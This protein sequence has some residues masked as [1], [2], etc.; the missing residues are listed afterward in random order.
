MERHP[1]TSTPLTTSHIGC[2]WHPSLGHSLLCSPFPKLCPKSRCSTGKHIYQ[3]SPDSGGL[4]TDVLTDKPPSFPTQLTFSLLNNSR[5]AL[6][7]LSFQQAGTEFSFCP[8][9]TVRLQRLSQHTSSLYLTF[10]QCTQSS[11]GLVIRLLGLQFGGDNLSFKHCL[12]G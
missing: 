5:N 4:A 10:F 9:G 6:C 7:S 1:D 8:L 2:S 11:K 3:E 12:G